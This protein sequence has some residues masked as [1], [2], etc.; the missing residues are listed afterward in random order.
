M[1]PTSHS[2]SGEGGGRRSSP[3]EV[4]SET[5]HRGQVQGGQSYKVAGVLRDPARPKSE[6][7][8][9]RGGDHR[10]AQEP[11]F[12]SASTAFQEGY[13]LSFGG[14]SAV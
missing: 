1:G 9:D 11:T 14:K 12:V 7:K 2:G 6:R 5:D 4:G 3:Q 8:N 10:G 13:C